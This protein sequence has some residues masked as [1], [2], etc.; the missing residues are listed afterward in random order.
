MKKKQELAPEEGKFTETVVNDDISPATKVWMD[1]AEE[2]YTKCIRLERQLEY[3]N[4]NKDIEF[5]TVL[6]KLSNSNNAEVKRI[7][8]LHILSMLT[9]NDKEKPIEE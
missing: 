7:S 4:T 9:S 1:R 2:Y 6:S 3:L 5:L 8:N